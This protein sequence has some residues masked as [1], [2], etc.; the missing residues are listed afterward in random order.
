MSFNERIAEVNAERDALR[1]AGPELNSSADAV[2]SAK[3]HAQD[4]ANSAA[5]AATAAATL[6]KSHADKVASHTARKAA[7]EVAAA[8]LAD[9]IK[10]SFLP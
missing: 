10:T 2:I 1:Q 8:K 7:H 3:Q 6:E 4:L 9:D 5:L